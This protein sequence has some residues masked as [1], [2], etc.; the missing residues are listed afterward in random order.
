MS[1]LVLLRHAKSSWPGGVADRDRPLAPRGERACETVGRF[2]GRAGLGPELVLSSPARRATE[3][4][5]LVLDAAGC[6]ADVRLD[7]RLYEDD[8]LAALRATPPEVG[9]L[10]VVGHEPDL[11][12]LASVLAGADVRLPTGG[13]AVLEL[14]GTWADQPVPG[15]RLHVLIGPR[16]LDAISR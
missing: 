14:T 15:G 12:R 6:G 16:Q 7:E 8:P 10:M 11:V 13:V 1:Q 9:R 3:T 4:A 2:L 5:A